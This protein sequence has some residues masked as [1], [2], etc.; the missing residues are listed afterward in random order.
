[1]IETTDGVFTLAEFQ[2][3]G[4][5]TNG[6]FGDP[7]FNLT[8]I[9]DWSFSLGFNSGSAAIDMGNPALTET[10][11][12]SQDFFNMVRIL[13]FAI[14]IGASEFWMEGLT[15]TDLKAVVV[16]PN[17]TTGVARL[18]AQGDYATFTILGLDG[19]QLATGKLINQEVNLSAFPN[20]VY[21]IRFSGTAGLAQS[22]VVKGS[23]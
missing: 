18:D 2:L 14:D 9:D 16:T 4:L 13:D 7:H 1:M 15:E 8:T 5:E 11:V 6:L 20:G 17:P 19:K 10:E 23:Y 3:A 12:G 21:V 22:R